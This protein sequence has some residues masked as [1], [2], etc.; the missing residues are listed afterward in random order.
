M[1]FL[2]GLMIGAAAVW[3]RSK[4]RAQKVK[5]LAAEWDISDPRNQLKFINA[6]DL[7]TRKPINV[8]AYKAVFAPA[9]KALEGIKPKHRLLAEVSMG[10]FLGTTGRAGQK[11]Q[12]RAFKSFNSKRVDF[13]IVDAFGEPKLVLEYHGSGHFLSK[14]AAQRDAVKR[15][16]LGSANVPLLEFNEGVSQ[17]EVA[18]KVRYWL[19]K[20]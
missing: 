7:K 9:E 4:W 20:R 3:L 11:A 10:S 15:L 14:D 8:E 6:V 18:N 12:D 2:I 5:A 13:L 16:A 17:A 19:T 1:D